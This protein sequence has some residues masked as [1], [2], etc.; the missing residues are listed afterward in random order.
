ML[1]CC[2]GSLLVFLNKTHMDS[3]PQKKNNLYVWVHVLFERK[4]LLKSDF[5]KQTKL[6]V[7]S[8]ICDLFF[9]ICYITVCLSFLLF[10]SHKDIFSRFVFTAHPPLPLISLGV[11]LRFRLS[12]QRRTQAHLYSICEVSVVASILHICCWDREE[13]CTTIPHPHLV[14]NMQ[15]WMSSQKYKRDMNLFL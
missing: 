14:W 11:T 12:W 8:C 10:F 13:P 1:A 4:R 15:A 5:L 7:N 3:L 9:F 2:R 6:S